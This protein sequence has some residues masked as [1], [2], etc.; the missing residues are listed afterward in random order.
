M[1]LIDDAA[2][3]QVKAAD[4]SH[5]WL[6][7]DL[8]G[9]FVDLEVLRE[10]YLDDVSL[11]GELV[12]RVKRLRV[13]F[14]EGQPPNL[15]VS[16]GERALATPGQQQPGIWADVLAR[17]SEPADRQTLCVPPLRAAER[18]QDVAAVFRVD[19]T[20]SP[21]TAYV[22]V[23]GLG[24]HDGV[25]DER[26]AWRLVELIANG[27]GREAP[28]FVVGVTSRDLL[29]T[30]TSTRELLRLAHRLRMSIV[31]HAGPDR[32]DLLTLAGTELLD[33]G[34]D[35][36]PVSLVACPTTKTGEGT[37]GM[38]RIR[39]NV[40]K[41][42]A[43]IAFRHDVG[44]DREPGR[45]LQLVRPLVSASRVSASERRLYA[46]VRELLADCPGAET[47]RKHVESTWKDHGYTALS[48]RD[49]EVPDELPVTRYVRYDL[50]LLLRERTPGHYDLLLSHHTPLR[51]PAVADWNTLLLPATQSVRTLLERLRDDVMRQAVGQADDLERA[52][53]ARA[54]ED[55][56]AKILD[57]VE[58]EHGGEVWPDQVREVGAFKEKKISP[59]YGTVCEY[60][61]RFVTLLPLVDR[62]TLLGEE[63]VRNAS[64]I[65]LWLNGLHAVT[66]EGLE[67]EPA[68][69]MEALEKD[70]AGLRWDPAV[71]MVASPNA[72]QRRSARKFPPGAVWFPVEIGTDWWQG[73]PSIAARNR[74]VMQEVDR[75][76]TLLWKQE[77]G[78]FPAQF[79]LGQAP[80]IGDV[81]SAEDEQRY[82]FDDTCAA[83]RK[84]KLTQHDL[85][86]TI[87]YP[88][89]DVRPVI[90]LRIDKVWHDADDA[91]RRGAIFV[92]D[93]SDRVMR[94]RDELEREEPIGMLRPVQR[95][96]LRSGLDRIQAIARDVLDAE[97][98][99]DPWGYLRIVKGASPRS[100]ALT[101]PIIEQLHVA[102]W[103][104]DA[105]RH[106][107]IVCDGNH[108]VV[109]NAWINGAP[110][111]AVAIVSQPAAPY[112]ARPFGRL[113]WD[114]TAGNELF[115]SPDQAS[116]YAVRAV[117][118]EHDPTLSQESKELLARVPEERRY[119][120]Y[121]RDLETGFGYMG[122]QGGRY[123]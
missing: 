1:W 22:V 3:K 50:L 89:A 26:G 15:L 27:V 23:L 93:A 44:S 80:A 100:A 111:A 70:G 66:A 28:V 109:L 34:S 32:H 51:P 6:L 90:L 105:G 99:L 114:C 73:C 74:D 121:F 82:S 68:L 83:L 62:P 38:A 108:R 88:D 72:E 35:T 30:G 31:L 18:P 85:N 84:V 10:P 118:L 13:P 87:A 48:D 9:P 11:A 46:K 58:E 41:G 37:P 112:Y 45:P 40:W 43:E 63:R 97:S 65:A 79:V 117:D 102:D 7:D 107:F 113:E 54:F 52:E 120:R 75:I 91:P 76:L 39:V 2:L 119:R 123:H 104:S 5:V 42:E 116:K 106:E 122:G 8:A 49:G 29:A 57:D 24:E 81:F 53:Q 21:T 78:R 101:P 4:P 110:T 94:E 33:R 16:Y 56:V 67:G 14:T 36:A 103:E 95:Y 20:R 55:A 98:D 71:E 25:D 60:D 12:E 86:G 17:L 92:F 69:T 59:T 64:K 115:A 77:G 19:A 47:F 61:Y 96:V